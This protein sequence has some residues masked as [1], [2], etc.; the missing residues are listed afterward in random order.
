V[1]TAAMTLTEFGSLVAIVV[2]YA[3]VFCLWWFIFRKGNDD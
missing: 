3:V 2:G 1:T